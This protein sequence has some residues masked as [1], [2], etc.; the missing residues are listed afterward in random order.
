MSPVCGL[1]QGSWL[2]LSPGEPCGLPQGSGL[3]EGEAGPGRAVAAHFDEGEAGVGDGLCGDDTVAA[4][5]ELLVTGRMRR[6]LRPGGMGVGGEEK[7][8]E[9]GDMGAGAR[10]GDC[11]WLASAI[12]SNNESADEDEVPGP[13]GVE[14]GP[15]GVVAIAA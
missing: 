4:G 11:G 13:G 8:P 5:I 15:V 6:A 14:P 1:P 3:L 12:A 9:E 2:T 7:E 10:G